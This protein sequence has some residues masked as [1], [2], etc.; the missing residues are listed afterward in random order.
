MIIKRCKMMIRHVDNEG[1]FT[2][3][4]ALM[5]MMLLTIIGVTAINT[6]TTG[7]M[8]TAAEEAIRA[9]SYVAESGV[10]QA[11]GETAILRT[12]FVDLA[13]KKLWAAMASGTDAASLPQPRW[14][15]AL[16][17]ND[18]TG[19]GHN[20]PTGKVASPV[21]S[22]LPGSKSKWVDQFTAGVLWT[23]KGTLGNDTYE[24]RV[25]NNVDTPPNPIPTDP[26]Q[27]AAQIDTDGLIVVG[28][29]TTTTVRRNNRSAV[30]VVLHGA[31]GPGPVISG[32]YAQSSGGA[33]KNSSAADLEAV[34]LNDP[35]KMSINANLM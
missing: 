28:A 6:S 11:I 8:I 17:G 15:F 34:S 3:I 7:T 21:A 27:A 30:E 1:G 16:N 35:T 23:D 14:S 5:L 10:A 19:N 12:Q 20:V 29:I 31:F 33:G 32:S 25:W 13:Q 4:A 9:T 22:P 24:V 2:M 18:L 26:A